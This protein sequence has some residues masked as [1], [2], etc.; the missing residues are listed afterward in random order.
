[1]NNFVAKRDNFD[2]AIA[3]L[4]KLKESSKNI[5]RTPEIRKTDKLIGFF[6]SNITGAELEEVV[7]IVQG[8]IVSTNTRINVAFKQ[9]MEVYNALAA[10]D[11]EYISGIV[12]A[13]NQ[14]IDAMNK[15]NDNQK[16]IVRT[17]A[18]LEK[19]VNKLDEL[20]T[21]FNNQLSLLSGSNWES[22]LNNKLEAIGKVEK[23]IGEYSK[24]LDSIE[25]SISKHAE[26]LNVKIENNNAC[27]NR[28]EESIKTINEKNTFL[29]TRQDAFEEKQNII[30]KSLEDFKQDTFDQTSNLNKRVDKVDLEYKDADNKLNSKIDAADKKLSEN[31]SQ[32]EQKVKKLNKWNLILS[33]VL[34]ILFT[35][36]VAVVILCLLKIL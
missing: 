14:A 11:K 24:K 29:S 25:N 28:I 32:L 16:E 10:L 31:D 30:Y 19:T 23:C 18:A 9:L 20:S 5:E 1:M 8:N 12:N 7:N 21:K 33:I 26:E 35:G 22:D 6:P 4:N 34:G 15:A 3:N 2:A 27:I 17:I 13:T 36:L